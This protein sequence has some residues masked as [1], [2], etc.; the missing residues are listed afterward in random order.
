MKSFR[1]EEK[2]QLGL[3]NLGYLLSRETQI[4][5]DGQ[6]IRKRVFVRRVSA[7]LEVP[8]VEKASPDVAGGR[9]CSVVSMWMEK[10]GGGGGG[11]AE[12]RQVGWSVRA[13]HW[14]ALL[15]W[16]KPRLRNDIFSHPSNKLHIQQIAGPLPNRFFP[17]ALSQKLQLLVGLDYWDIMQES[18]HNFLLTN[19]DFCLEMK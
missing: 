11:G 16:N 6:I 14:C 7:K 12:R 17:P 5:P 9:S 1:K 19:R 10:E 2:R 13:F 4:H 3:N 18:V 8:R 15:R